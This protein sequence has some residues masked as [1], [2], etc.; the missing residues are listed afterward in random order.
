M[1]EGLLFLIGKM[2]LRNAIVG[3]N[4]YYC[5]QQL[6]QDYKINPNQGICE[7]ADWVKI[8]LTDIPFMPSKA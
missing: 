2:G 6:I 5:L 4:A 7:L 1:W 8:L 3:E